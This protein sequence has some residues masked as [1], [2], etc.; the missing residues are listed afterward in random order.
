MTLPRQVIPGADYMITR[1]C[2]ER[3]FFLRPDEET[4]NA[5]IYCLALAAMRAEVDVLFLLGMSNHYHAGIHD[6]HGNFPIFS[7]HFHALLARCL[8]AHL[9]RFEGFWSTDPTSVVRLVE[10]NDVLEKMTY[11]YANPAAA[12]LVDTIDDWPG[13]S[14]FKAALGSQEIVAIRPAF[15]FRPDG[16]LPEVVTLRI[17]R[18]RGFED[19][20]K[21]EWGALV[22]E[23]VRTAEAEHRERRRVAGKSVMGREAILRQSP[24]DHPGSPE[25]HFNISRRV[26]A[27]RKWPRI[28]VI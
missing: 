23:R 9:G 18:P 4:T 26:A 25:P 24:F 13:A 28:E 3:R 15:F 21:V 12:D 17:A 22:T 11:A 19:L 14:S 7:E 10:P 2:S 6:T 27:K 8:N 16:E 20:T 5:F 1:R